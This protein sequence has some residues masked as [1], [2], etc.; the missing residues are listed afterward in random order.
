VSKFYAW[1]RRHSM[2]LYITGWIILVAIL[3]SFNADFKIDLS[4]E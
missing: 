3:W 2:A 1:A 4:K